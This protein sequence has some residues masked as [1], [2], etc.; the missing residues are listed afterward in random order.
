MIGRTSV[1]WSIVCLLAI[2]VRGQCQ[3]T[4]SDKKDNVPVLQITSDGVKAYSTEQGKV[5]IG[6]LASD[7]HGHVVIAHPDSTNVWDGNTLG[8]FKDLVNGNSISNKSVLDR[9]ESFVNRQYPADV[10]DVQN[11]KPK[12]W[13]TAT[14]EEKQA[15]YDKVS[16][17]FSK[18]SDD[19]KKKYLNSYVE[20][21]APINDS[22]R[23][24]LRAKVQWYQ[25]P[26]DQ[27]VSDVIKDYQPPEA[28]SAADQNLRCNDLVQKVAPSVRL[29]VVEEVKA[30]TGQTAP[31]VTA[32]N[33]DAALKAR[34]QQT[35]KA[36]PAPTV[37][38]P[39]EPKPSASIEA[40]P[41]Q[42][43]VDNKPGG[44]VIT[45]VAEIDS[46]R[47][48]EVTS[49]TFDATTGVL[50]LALHSGKTV[51][52]Q[53]DVDDFTV[54]IRCVFDHQVDPSISMFPGEKLGF[55]TVKCPKPL[56]KTRF[57]KL[58]HEAD[59]L[60]YKMMFNREGDHRAIAA[61][62]IPHFD[63]LTCEMYNTWTRHQRVDLRAT[64]ARFGIQ[65]GRLV[66]RGLQTKVE[67]EGV[68]YNASYFHESFHRLARALEEHFADLANEFEE[69]EEFRRLT[70]CVAL[71]KWI[72]R[73]SIPFDRKAIMARTVAETDFPMYEPYI[74]WDCLF[75][76]RTLDGWR[77]NLTSAEIEWTLGRSSLTLKPTAG[78]ALEFLSTAKGKDYDLRFT[79]ITDGPVEFIIRS[80]SGRNGASV[81]ID[82][83]GR[84][85]MVELFLANGEWTAVAPG[86]GEKGKVEIPEPKKGEPSQSNDFGIRVPPGSKIT[87]FT[88]SLRWREKS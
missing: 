16:D 85:R 22:W 88:A 21:G 33:I 65:N 15:Y 83:K 67:V 6:S 4:P 17:L 63:E 44:V 26:T 59:V 29:V 68:G 81:T 1:Y 27:K 69:F 12:H 79:V 25:V 76:G 23:P 57:G 8:G 72:K 3:D 61:G 41:G 32:N 36:Q 84:A 37:E 10:A 43:K 2:L 56:H 70:E 74:G 71:A 75:N 49:A 55:M 82:T 46:L 42:P 14:A 19:D 53:M 66:R 34:A 13:K 77:T 31:D 47:P 87:L 5:V 45:A 80:G 54:A 7:G 40:T 11:A 20:N 64:G 58:M 48:E 18:A 73:H 30:P 24:E 78:K 39:P 60:L 9:M 35:Q 52:C 51:M 28:K 86:F 38:R 62:I 50:T